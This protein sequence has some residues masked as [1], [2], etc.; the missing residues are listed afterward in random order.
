MMHQ[1]C[2]NQSLDLS[3]DC[4][5]GNY[6]QQAFPT[7]VGQRY[8]LSFYYGNNTD[9]PYAS[10]RV[11]LSGA[12]VLLSQDLT[13][14]NSTPK[15]V[16]YTL[17][18]STFIADAS[19]TVLR[20]THLGAPT[21]GRGLILDAIAVTPVAEL[22]TA[23]S[24]TNVLLDSQLIVNG[25]F[26]NLPLKPSS[27]PANPGGVANPTMV[28]IGPELHVFTALELSWSSET[29]KVYRIQRTP[30]LEQPQWTDLEPLVSGTGT[31]VSVFDSARNHPRGFYRVLIVQ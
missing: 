20:F 5:P 7:V 9:D 14:S 12:A 21:F 13:H 15:D 28:S 2:G 26:E 4:A 19:T 17:F 27:S 10:G 25:S 18:Q 22:S 11:S 23:A 8:V 6:I 29:N 3:G 31:D 1:N 30:S 24:S 16:N